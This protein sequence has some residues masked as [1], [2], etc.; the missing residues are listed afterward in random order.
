[1]TS[2]SATPQSDRRAVGA[3]A[4]AAPASATA[5]GPQPPFRGYF[6]PEDL[7]ADRWV[8]LTALVLCMIG[9]PFLLLAAG[10]TMAWSVFLACSV[11]ATTLVWL[12]VCSASLYHLPLRIERRRLR[13]LD[14]AAIFLL[15]AGTCTPFTTA[16][17]HGAEALAVTGAV[18]AMALAGAF[19]KLTR[20]QSFPGF[21]TTGKLLLAGM[22]L[23]GV[24]PVLHAADARAV[25]LIVAGL[26]I[27]L[28]GAIL[29]RRPQR[30]RNTVWHT[31]VIA[32]AACHYAAILS[33][34]VLSR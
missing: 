10:K 30:Y 19:Y 24:A 2:P 1:M 22:V 16:L 15:V 28:S 27:Y 6:R 11:Y 20:P 29:R 14:H 17:L 23:V 34:I 13:Q 18:W 9:V 32:G 21:S 4:G 12:F 7:A 33:G 26:A 5:A 25:A 31:L 8:H 3:A